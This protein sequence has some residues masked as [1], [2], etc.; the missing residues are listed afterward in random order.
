MKCVIGIAQSRLKKNGPY[1]GPLLIASCLFETGLAY[2]L[3]AFGYVKTHIMQL[4]VGLP[5]ISFQCVSSRR[6]N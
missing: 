4:V 3:H 5:S 2:V 6:G 1:N